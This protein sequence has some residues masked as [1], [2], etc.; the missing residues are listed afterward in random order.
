MQKI[1]FQNLP[2]TT[3]P[4]NATNLNA[5][6]TNVEDAINIFD[7]FNDT[8]GN[9]W[10]EMM[11]NK[12]DYCIAHMDSSKEN[13]SAFIN[14]GWASV[15]YGL[16]FFS[17]IGSFYQLVWF[18]NRGTYYCNY[19]GI[20]YEYKILNGNNYQA[21]EQVIGTFIDG[22]PI[23]RKTIT[24]TG[25]TSQSQTIAT[26][27]NV[28]KVVD[29]KCFV[30]NGTTF[31]NGNSVFYGD[32]NWATQVYYTNGYVVIESGTAFVNNFKTG[33]TIYTTIEYTKTTD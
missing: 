28:D 7:L 21:N 16:G 9:D 26:L 30:Q 4:V 20:N 6:Q 27:T 5:I 31:R 12:L 25:D 23:Y 19:D 18:S 14:G 11:R 22:K 32:I 3:T 15:V 2:S 29:I 1:N 24:A 33:A 8:S 17:K 10:K 13:T